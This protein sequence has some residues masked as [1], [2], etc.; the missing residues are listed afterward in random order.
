MK[1]PLG[2]PGSPT[3]LGPM[4]YYLLGLNGTKFEKAVQFYT[5]LEKPGQIKKEENLGVFIAW[6]L[7]WHLSFF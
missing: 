7:G 4:Y 6:D 5:W 1:G 2:T 3:L